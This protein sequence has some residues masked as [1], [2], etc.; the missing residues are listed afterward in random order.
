[1][2]CL[3]PNGVYVELMESTVNDGVA[4]RGGPLRRVT[5]PVPPG[6]C[7][8]AVCFYTDLMGLKP[9]ID[10]E[11][12]GTPQTSVLLYIKNPALHRVCIGILL[13]AIIAL[14]IP[15]QLTVT[16]YNYQL[17][18]ISRDNIRAGEDFSVEDTLTTEKS[19]QEKRAA[20]LSVYDFNSKADE[21]IEKRVTTAFSSMRE[22]LAK[23]KKPEPAPDKLQQEFESVLR[24]RLADNDFAAIQ[25]KKFRKNLE[26]GN[27][28]IWP[29]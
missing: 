10:R 15:S 19:K 29:A 18:D 23:T 3:D 21:D 20:V 1:M 11:L 4:G 6:T 5:I 26:D 12:S 9:L 14:L 13:S 7:D 16:K 17:G 27:G 24:V 22:A 25:K 2:V 8:A 28:N